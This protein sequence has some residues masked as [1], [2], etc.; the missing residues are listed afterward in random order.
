MIVLR[1]PSGFTSVQL[2]GPSHRPGLHPSNLQNLSQSYQQANA[3]REGDFQ[4]SENV[5]AGF[6][7]AHFFDPS[8]SVSVEV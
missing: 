8:S 2:L 5:M 7:F 4:V 1:K 3:A 6:V